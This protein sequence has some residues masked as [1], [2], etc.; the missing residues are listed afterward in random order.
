ME[1][2]EKNSVCCTNIA[3]ECQSSLCFVFSFFHKTQCS[4]REGEEDREELYQGDLE[5][6]GAG[7][8]GEEQ[9][10]IRVL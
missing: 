5:L 8:F 3:G 10:D 1:A 4:S 2:P 9:G 7:D 6:T